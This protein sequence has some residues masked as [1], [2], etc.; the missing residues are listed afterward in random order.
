MPT[1]DVPDARLWYQDTGGDGVPVVFVH[2]AA[3]SSETWEHH[4]PAFMAAGY[5]C[6]TYDLRGWGR[7]RQLPEAAGRGYLSDD[8]EAL[9]QQLRLGPFLLV[10]AAYGGMG[11]LDYALRFQDRLRAF[12]LAT[13]QGAIVDPEYAATIGRIVPPELRAVPIELR[14]LGPSYRVENPAGVQ[15]W[16]QI[17]HQAGGETAPRQARFLTLTL[18][19]LETLRVPTLVLAADADL[20]APSSLMRQLADRIPGAEFATVADAGHSAHWERPTEWNQ[21]VLE[22]LARH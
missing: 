17:I 18:S 19:L 13:S 16:L 9:T 8:L 14:E 10:A 22:F 12:V 20:L 6:I 11:A 15:R 4:L 7:S 2:P 1:I 5:R 3:A 21:T